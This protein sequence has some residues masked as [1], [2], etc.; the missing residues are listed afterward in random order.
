MTEPVERKPTS[1]GKIRESAAAQKPAPRTRTRGVRTSSGVR[2]TKSLD[3]DTDAL[4]HE[5]HGMIEDAM[6]PVPERGG[7]NVQTE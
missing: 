2:E 6:A 1:K 4:Q 5:I 3:D 7:T